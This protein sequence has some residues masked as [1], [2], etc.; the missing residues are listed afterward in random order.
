MGNHT[1][2]LGHTISAVDADVT[3]QI[4]T[5]RANGV[6]ELDLAMLDR[7]VRPWLHELERARSANADPEEFVN[8]TVWMAQLIFSE[9]ILNTQ[10]KSNPDMVIAKANQMVR[11]LATS[12][13]ETLN[14]SLNAKP[15]LVTP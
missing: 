2:P 15:Q 8:S 4:Q 12:L 7:V 6:D 11:L 1:S 3:K 13:Q 14:A 9:L 10:E 5:M